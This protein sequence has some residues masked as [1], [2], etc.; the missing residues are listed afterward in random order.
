MNSIK[1]FLVMFFVSLVASCGGGGSSSTPSGGTPSAITVTGTAATGSAIAN[2]DL[3][4]K[5]ATGAQA[6]VKT[7]ATTGQYSLTTS[8]TP[9]LLVQV[10]T[11][12]ARANYPAGTVFYSVSADAVPSVINITPLTDLI[13]RAWYQ[14][15]PTPVTADVAFANPV[16]NPPP[17][18]GVVTV[19]EN[20]VR[21]IVG[22][23][24]NSNGVNPATLNLISTPFTAN[25]TGVDAV[26][27]AT[28]VIAAS[29]TVTAGTLTT[30][31]TATNG[32]IATTAVSGTA[33]TSTGTT[34]PTNAQASVI[35]GIQAGIDAMQAGLSTKGMQLADTDVLPYLDVNTMNG[36][37]NRAQTA[38]E[39][40]SERPK[41]AGD[42]TSMKV[43][44]LDSVAGN[45]AHVT[46]LY[47]K[48]TNGVTGGS[49][50]IPWAYVQQTNGQW[51]LAGDMQIAQAQIWSEGNLVSGYVNMLQPAYG[52][53][54]LPSAPTVNGTGFSNTPFVW[55]GTRITPLMAKPGG[56][57]TT[58]T[59]DMYNCP[60][61]AV[62]A[63]AGRSYTLSLPTAAGTV[64]YNYTLRATTTDT[65]SITNLTAGLANA[66]LGAPLTVNWT[67]PTTFTVIGVQFD[68]QV[69]DG[70]GASCLPGVGYPQLLPATVTNATVTLPAT[71]NGGAVTGASVGVAAY[72]A[73][74]EQ[75][76]TQFNF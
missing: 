24:L 11:T 6:T 45:V 73:H 35:T 75:A 76:R 12:V 2:A 44:S 60:A 27:D 72:G 66:K 13:V 62:T 58:V 51:L 63:V 10:T 1:L 21:Q 47:T 7:N 71:C 49:M 74:G 68:P 67:L 56:A 3:T 69:Q 57:T 59:H 25:G 55:G 64:T 5:D 22:N 36:G 65:P 28:P 31:L 30:T 29:G 34:V 52:G 20:V 50:L 53:M 48:T 40:A 19:I 70:T 33:T 17:Q 37:L 42:G 26:L 15:Q 43:L 23:A 18:P 14:A 38:V 39:F 16:T 32:A 41:A 61:S 8:L 46:V 54:T 4:F 9:P